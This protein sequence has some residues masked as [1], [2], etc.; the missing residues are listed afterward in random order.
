LSE[1]SEAHAGIDA[2]QAQCR[3]E[4]HASGVRRQ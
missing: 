3:A 2:Q 1:S 4:V